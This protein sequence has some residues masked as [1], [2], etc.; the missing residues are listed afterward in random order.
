MDRQ[1]VYIQKLS[2]D[3]GDW[4]DLLKCLKSDAER[5]IKFLMRQNPDCRFR[6]WTGGEEWREKKEK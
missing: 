1:S 5:I 3:K 2:R 4:F 6:I